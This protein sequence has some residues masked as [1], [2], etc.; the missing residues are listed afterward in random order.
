MK[1]WRLLYSRLLAFSLSFS[2]GLVLVILIANLLTSLST[3]TSVPVIK[4]MPREQEAKEQQMAIKTYPSPEYVISLIT[5]NEPAIRRAIYKEIF[6]RPNKDSIYYDYLRDL[7][8]PER[9]DNVK[10]DYVKLDKEH[11]RAAIIKFLHLANPTIIVMQKVE[12]NQWIV[13]DI[14][15][16]RE[17][18][19]SDEDWAYTVSLVEPGIYEILINQATSDTTS[20]ESQFIIFKLI[21]N[22]LV[23]VGVLLQTKFIATP[24]QKLDK[25]WLNKAEILE[26][27]QS[28]LQIAY[29]PKPT[30]KIDTYKS[31]VKLTGLK[32]TKRWSDIDLCWHISE[33]APHNRR[34]ET[35]N[36]ISYSQSFLVWD[37][38]LQRFVTK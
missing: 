27:Y 20:Y 3:P 15:S 24:S 12:E 11:S 7:D 1:L 18:F 2:F 13:L 4:K 14:L 19:Y 38:Q 5:H 6:L 31:I 35:L 25:D 10:L 29:S 36:F 32:E 9:A 37:S 26:R 33:L 30:L 21:N 16:T 17:K 22:K 34:Y 28:H 23:K 8:F